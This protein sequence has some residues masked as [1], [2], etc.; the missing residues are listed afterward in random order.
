MI[1]IDMTT[2]PVRFLINHKG[3]PRP[4]WTPRVTEFAI[5]S[6]D[7]GP[8]WQ[9]EAADELGRPARDLAIIYG[10][11]PAGFVQTFP[12]DG[13]RPRMLATRRTYFVAAGGADSLY[14]MVFAMPVSQWEPILPPRPVEPQATTQPEG[15]SDEN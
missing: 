2:M 15:S 8:I 11:V 14:K 6:E 12:E 5:A 1:Q 3:W 9:L 10:Q 4:L 13:L 7:D